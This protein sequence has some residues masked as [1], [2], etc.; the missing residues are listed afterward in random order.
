[1]YVCMCTGVTSKQ[2]KQSLEDGCQSVADLLTNTGAG[3]CCG[4]CVP[5]L[6]SMVEEFHT[7]ALVMNV[8]ISEGLPM[9]SSAALDLPL[10]NTSGLK[11]KIEHKRNEAE[12]PQPV[13]GHVRVSHS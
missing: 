2:I 4:S 6:Q 11:D 3:G 5:M 9:L 12:V 13:H 8:E 7:P 10:V 1:M